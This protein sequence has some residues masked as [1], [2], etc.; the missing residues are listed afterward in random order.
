METKYSLSEILLKSD[1]TIEDE[2]N[3]IEI[4]T[5]SV[6]SDDNENTI[7]KKKN[8]ENTIK[9][10]KTIFNRI[11]LLN[12]YSL[13]NQIL[14]EDLIITNDTYIYSYLLNSYILENKTLNKIID[15][16]NKIKTDS[17][18]EKCSLNEFSNFYP[19]DPITL[20][21]IKLESEMKISNNRCYDKSSLNQALAIR[22]RDPFTNEI[23]ERIKQ[24][25][26]D[27]LY[28]T[29]TIEQQHIILDI[30]SFTITRIK[31]LI[32]IVIAILSFSLQSFKI[33]YE[34]NMN[35]NV[36]I[37]NVSAGFIGFFLIFNLLFNRKSGLLPNPN[38]IN[39]FLPGFD[40]KDLID[41]L[42]NNRIDIVNRKYHRL[43]DMGLIFNG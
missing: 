4:F 28:D 14:D 26:I 7:K 25:D 37:G 27:T 17:F 19:I 38:I 22:Q 23:I 21:E 24:S 13:N 5:S 32:K 30:E 2:F 1:E 16:I 34:I 8:I 41:G 20:E 15:T 18:H 10:Y 11:L 12:I 29:L 6:T 39:L 36:F 3:K 35:D 31:I 43:D 9:K 33:A 42:R 40:N